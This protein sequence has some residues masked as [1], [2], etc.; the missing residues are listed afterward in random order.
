MRDHAIS[1]IIL[2]P[3]TEVGGRHGFLG[4]VGSK[5]AFVQ[6][7]NAALFK[8]LDHFEA[9]DLPHNLIPHRERVRKAAQYLLDKGFATELGVGFGILITALELD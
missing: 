9:E 7:D 2:G 5:S 4:Q 3:A 1:E 8:L 6:L